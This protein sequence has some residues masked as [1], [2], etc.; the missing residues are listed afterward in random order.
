LCDNIGL[1]CERAKR[2]S[3]RIEIYTLA[4]PNPLAH[5]LKRASGVR[6]N[7]DIA[8]FGYFVFTSQKITTEF[9]RPP[10]GGGGGGG[11]GVCGVKRIN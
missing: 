11:G 3:R 10:N 1:S 7:N 5:R 6:N 4:H 8:R 2:I 9:W